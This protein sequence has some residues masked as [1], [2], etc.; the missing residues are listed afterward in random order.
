[1]TRADAH[2]DH[3]ASDDPASSFEPHR[4]P[5]TGL[6]Y[7]MLGSIATAEDVVQEAYLRWHATD[8]SNVQNPRAFLSRTVTRLCLDHL[9]ST[10]VQ[11]EQY[12]G[13]WLP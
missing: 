6:A 4:A 8:R 9:K 10:Q 7:R 2:E 5:L 13:P 12:I 11:R 3:H 1:M